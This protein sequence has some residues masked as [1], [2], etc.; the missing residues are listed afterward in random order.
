MKK[1]KPFYPLTLLL[2]ATPEAFSTNSFWKND[3]NENLTNITKRAGLDNFSQNVAG[4][5]WAGTGPNGE[6]AGTM[7]LHYSRI[8]AMTVTDDNKLIVMFDL[9]WNNAFDQNRIDPGVAVSAD[10]GHT[11]ERKTAW[12]FNDSKA[13]T[14]R[15]MDPTILYNSIDGSIYAMHGTW[16]DGN[17]N[18]FRDRVNYFNDNLWA[19]TIYKSTDGGLTWEKSAEFSK[20]NNADILEKVKMRRQP[21]VGFLGGVG[22]G[23][24]MRDGTLVFPIQT[25]HGLGKYNGSIA[26]TIMYSKDNGKTWDMPT[27]DNALAP[28]QS[29]LE[30][31]VFEIGDKLVMTGRED[32][33]TKARWAYYTQDLGKTWQVY[34]PVNDFSTTTAA[35]SQGSSIYVTL[36]NG[37]RVLLVSKPDGN[38][39]DGYKR[40]NLSLWML[41]AK[42][43]NHKHKV[44]VIRP[45]SG[46]GAGAGYSSL[47]YKEGNLFI[48]FEDDGDITVKNLAEHMQAIES[49]ALEWNLPDEIQIEVDNINQ[50]AH[51]NQGQKDELVAKMRKANDYAVAQSIAIDQAMST[52]KG[53]RSNFDKQAQKL[54]KALPSQRQLFTNV[55]NQIAQVTH[56][57]DKTYLDYNAVQSLSDELKAR[58]FALSQTKLDFPQYRSRTEKLQSYNTD[59]LY[60]PFEHF[61][62][63]HS[64]GSKHNY[65]T[66]GFNTQLS[67]NFRAGFFIEHSNRERESYH[68]G[69]RAKYDSNRHQLSGFAR[70]RTVKYDDFLEQHK[71]ADIYLNYGYYFPINS[72][73]T[74]TPALGAY[75]SHGYRSLIDE[76]V[77]IRKHTAYATD[78]SLNI[79][80]K[81]DNVNAYI[82]PNAAL[83]KNSTLLAQSNDSNNRYKL[84]DGTQ[85]VYS[86]STGIEKHFTNGL[87]VG[88][89]VKL[90][91]D[92]SKSS[93]THFGLNV[94]Y[95]W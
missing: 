77:A 50:L 76:D 79:V 80:Y 4:R 31:M 57:A 71:N 74:L 21:V 46:N 59:I 84:N 69:I 51:L 94:G 17:Q 39:N 92:S 68:F 93:Q 13:P 15:A 20:Q 40:G 62:V 18:W 9:R 65:S 89:E 12:T 86:V 81:L 75:L 7:P 3:L 36:K 63:H 14:R 23:I 16:A 32:N 56:S 91:K 43:P 6:V 48:A 1:A 44:A 30:N 22:S 37:R 26:T 24:V 88:T 82:R 49:K 33:R 58:F 87:T 53:D 8:P 78:L 66:V 29:S 34:E 42:D 10:G 47:A 25:A 45:D 64:I 73:L 85:M 95:K 35:P 52:L 83:V 70:Y 54:V 2:V 28:N 5:P 11:W 41:D 67:E 55:L 72:K 38:G 61:F 60:R 19:A 90:Q 27:I